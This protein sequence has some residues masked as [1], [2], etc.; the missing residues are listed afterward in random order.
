MRYL[1][2]KILENLCVI[3]HKCMRTS[4][5]HCVTSYCSL[6]RANITQLTLILCKADITFLNMKSII[7]EKWISPED[8]LA[9]RTQTNHYDCLK[10]LTTL[11]IG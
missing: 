10:Q 7:Y 9:H 1:R 6:G 4:N 11:L 5:V 3:G 2:N 8:L